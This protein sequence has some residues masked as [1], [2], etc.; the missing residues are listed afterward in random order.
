[1]IPK[2]TAELPKFCNIPNTQWYSTNGIFQRLK[3]VSKPPSSSTSSSSTTT[4]QQPPLL[5]IPP[6]VWGAWFNQTSDRRS[7]KLEWG[8]YFSRSSS[9]GSRNAFTSC[10]LEH[11]RKNADAFKPGC[12]KLVRWQQRPC[13]ISCEEMR[14]KSNFNISYCCM[15]PQEKEHIKIH[16]IMST[17]SSAS[18][19]GIK[20]DRLF[21]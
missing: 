18:Q 20:I 11:S 14:W 4:N 9:K 13:W 16:L 17:A 19:H 10:T 8:S 7:R 12:N 21:Y 15:I 2:T 1:M 5:L 3:M 6:V